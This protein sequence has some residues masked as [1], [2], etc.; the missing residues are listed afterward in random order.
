MKRLLLLVS[1]I[2]FVCIYSVVDSNYIQKVS[3]T[4]ALLASNGKYPPVIQTVSGKIVDYNLSN[5]TFDLDVH[6]PKTQGK[7]RIKVKDAESLLRVIQNEQFDVCVE[8]DVYQFQFLSAKNRNGF[9]Y[10]QYLYSQGVVAQYQTKQV[11]ASESS[12]SF[13]ISDTRL[14]IRKWILT[15]LSNHFGEEEAGFLNA[16][17]LGDK[18]SFENFDLYK[19][20]GLAHI[21][22]ISGLHFNVIFAFIKKLIPIKSKN[23]KSLILLVLMSFVMILVGEAYSAQRAY[24]MIFY[25]EMCFLLYRK[26]D[27]YTSL[28]FS[29]LM[30][31][32]IQPSAVLSTGLHLSYYAYICVAILYR[33]VFKKPLKSQLMEGLRFSMAI[34][35]FLLPAT[36]YFFHN[37]NVYGFI[38]NTL[39]VPLS[40]VILVMAIFMLLFKCLGISL[41]F[42]GLVISI[43]NIIGAFE[44]LTQLMPMQLEAFNLIKKYDFISI[45]W[46]LGILGLSLCIWKWYV[47]RKKLL[48]VTL[49]LVV[50]VTFY[51]DAVGDRIGL[52]TFYDVGHGDMSLIQLK[53]TRVLID[54]GDGKNSANDI[55]RANGVQTLDYLI[56]SHAHKDHLGGTLELMD[57][58]QIEHI[59][60]N[61]STLDKLKEGDFDY[62]GDLI[63]IDSNDDSNEDSNIYTIT[64]KDKSMKLVVSPEKGKKASEDPN[65]DAIIVRFEYLN[66]KGYFLGDISSDLLKTIDEG[67]IDF[68][69]TPHHG[70]K[71]ALDAAFYSRNQVRMALTSCSSKYD[72]PNREVAEMMASF[73]ILHFTTY[74]S[75]QVDLTFSRDQLKMN[76]YLNNGGFHGF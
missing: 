5:Q 53:E 62:N 69:K 73:D 14:I 48:F 15:T 59:I 1:I 33:S 36:L 44:A 2:L 35:V 16:L 22:A 38:A 17:I 39:I 51:Q 60:L 10:D 57:Q 34:Q 64:S 20:L 3:E 46:I 70:S 54:T 72:M 68:I 76:T 42:K 49:I 28:A 45:L 27:I 31:I 19:N 56:L 43:Q 13:S 47:H 41:L 25:S 50:S 65:D 52:I 4:K 32:L 61:Q 23:I 6:T 71:T 67:D 55:L 63:V 66:Y 30:I 26:S 11:I 21:F 24:F 37:T 7:W 58:M 18:S 9:D 29:F 8:I 40:S 74:R 75:G 12:Q